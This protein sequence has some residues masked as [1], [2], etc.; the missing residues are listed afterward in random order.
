MTEKIHCSVNAQNDL[1]LDSPESALIL[2]RFFF[3]VLS[4]HWEA[5]T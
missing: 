1:V 4:F 2:G 3:M 5:A